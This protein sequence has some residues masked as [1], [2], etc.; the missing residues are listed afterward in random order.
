MKNP[1]KHRE[2]ILS[3]LSGYLSVPCAMEFMNGI[4][5]K[6]E[7]SSQFEIYIGVT[8]EIV[9]L[10]Q[11]KRWSLEVKV[12]F[13]WIQRVKRSESTRYIPIETHRSP[14]NYT[15]YPMMF[16]ITHSTSAVISEKTGAKKSIQLTTCLPSGIFVLSPDQ[17]SIDEL[18]T[19]R[20]YY[21]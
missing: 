10:P 1:I 9:V 11:Q 4:P 16:D 17:A 3:D 6:W 12:V 15:G 18:T 2:N 8:R 14:V 5:K 20:D 7:K 13:E 21:T 19:I